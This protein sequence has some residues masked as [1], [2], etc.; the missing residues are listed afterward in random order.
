M[1]RISDA[2]KK[3]GPLIDILI[4]AI[5]KDLKTLPHVV[6]AAKRH[7]RH[8]IGEVIIVAPRKESIRSLCREEGWRFVDENTVLPITKKDIR[9]RSKRWERSGWL[10]QQLLKLSGDK[11]CRARHFLVIDADT[12]FIRPHTF[13]KGE[14]TVFYTREWSQPE[15]FRAYARLMGS[16]ASAPR[17]F[18]TH[19]MLF[20]KEKL[21]E[22]KRHIEAR[23]R[24]GWHEAV[25][26]CI[27]RTSKFGFSEYET[28]GNFLYSR[29]PGSVKLRK[30]LNRAM[31]ASVDRMTPDRYKTLAA[32]YRSVSFHERKGYVRKAETAAARANRR[33]KAER[34]QS[35]S[36]AGRVAEAS[37]IRRGR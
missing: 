26:K 7:V 9:Y 16:C 5:E 2:A 10:F 11:L 20:E 23:H 33:G 34:R 36:G 24:M 25:L 17:S 12:V 4:P 21:A 1:P 27:D 30:A 19:Y 37:G 29:Y 22:L 3:K 6:R 32:R 18:V 31:S 14:K 15:Y 8:P 28:Y 35:R 13:L